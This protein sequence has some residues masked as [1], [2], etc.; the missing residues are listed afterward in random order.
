MPD[1]LRA[2]DSA[3]SGSIKKLHRLQKGNE[4]ASFNIELV[5]VPIF[6]RCFITVSLSN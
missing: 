1:A 2:R 4:I 3:S 5:I 6:P